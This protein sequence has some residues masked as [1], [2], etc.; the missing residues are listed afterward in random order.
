VPEPG[1]RIHG[2]S[3]VRLLLNKARAKNFTLRELDAL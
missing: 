1:E 2:E 3:R